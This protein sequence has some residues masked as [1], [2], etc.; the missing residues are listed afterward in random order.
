MKIYNTN[1]LK[2]T[3]TSILVWGAAGVG[4]TTLAST[5]PKP[6]LFLMFDPNGASTLR[7]ADGNIKVVDITDFNPAF[8]KGFYGNTISPFG[9]ELTNYIIDNEIKSIVVDSITA[10]DNHCM[11]YAI[12][13]SKTTKYAPGLQGYGCRATALKEVINNICLFCKSKNIDIMFTAHQSGW[14]KDE[15]TGYLVQEIAIGG[16]VPVSLPSIFDEIWYLADENNKKV[17]YTK[18]TVKFSPMKSRMFDC[19][20]SGFYIWDIKNQEHK[21]ENIFKNAKNNKLK[22]SNGEIKNG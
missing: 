9:E 17:I 10:L 18:S 13:V 19:T 14:T 6:I 4:K 8:I 12:K 2:N 20:E 22:L 16:K 5:L 11:D 21:L 7:H 1:E 3:N 15:M